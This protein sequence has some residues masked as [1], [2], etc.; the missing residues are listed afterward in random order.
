[1]ATL[2]HG[3]R[4]GDPRPDGFKVWLRASGAGTA[5]VYTR[6][7]G[8]TTWFLGD[9]QAIDVTKYNTAVLTVTG[10]SAATEY[11][12]YVEVDSVAGTTYTTIT[13]PHA[14]GGDFNIYAMSDCHE[15]ADAINNAADAIVTFHNTNYP[16]T[17]AIIIYHGDMINDGGDAAYCFNLQATQIQLA[18]NAFAKFPVLYMWDDWDFGGN[19]SNRTY[20]RGTSPTESISQCFDRWDWMWRDLPSP[21]AGC[22]GYHY[23]ICGVPIIVA[24]SRSNKAPCIGELLLS[25]SYGEPG[26]GITLTGAEPW[27]HMN[28]LWGAAQHSWLRDRITEYCERQLVFFVSTHTLKDSISRSAGG[29]P[30]SSGGGRDSTGIYHRAPRNDLFGLA[31]SLGYG[32]RGS[33]VVL[34]GDDHRNT[35]WWKQNLGLPKARTDYA[36]ATNDDLNRGYV[37]AQDIVL[38]FTEVVTQCGTSTPVGGSTQLF[39]Y[40]NAFENSGSN[41]AH[42]T[43]WEIHSSNIGRSVTARLRYIKVSTGLVST[44]AQGPS[45]GRVGDFYFDNG[46]WQYYN[47]TTGLQNQEYPPDNIAPQIFERAYVDDINGD[48]VREGKAARDP[49]GLLRHVDDI[50]DL[51]A[52]EERKQWKIRG[53]RAEW[54]P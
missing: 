42:F 10:L 30:S 9:T 8:T 19:N 31:A 3:P 34:S 37:T 14:G 43:V 41:N 21:V 27:T 33:L 2:T 36:I 17:P 23:E 52:D 45:I 40:G 13:M 32:W 53:E 46:N 47:S 12:Y 20:Q 48:L 44:S 28:D 39:G 18:I 16:T 49:D 38:N 50:G 6:Q 1:M 5:K 15:L 4:L 24:D 54:E 11:D 29:N 22:Q 25:G 7:T 35:M 26:Q 51:D